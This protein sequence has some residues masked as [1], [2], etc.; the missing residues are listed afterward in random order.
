VGNVRQ[1]H[2]GAS[3]AVVISITHS[4]ALSLAGDGIRVNAVCPGVID[5]RM[6]EETDRAVTR[7]NGIPEGDEYRRAVASVPLGRAGSPEEVASVICFLASQE[8]S[9]VTG[10][11]INVDG[12]TRQD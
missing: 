2:Y 12:G 6:W 4:A 5:T 8:A 3:K 7:M 1:A 11:T 10:Q 9:Y